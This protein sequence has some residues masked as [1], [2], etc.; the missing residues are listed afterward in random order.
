MAFISRGLTD[1]EIA[2]KTNLALLIIRDHIDNNLEKL[3]LNSHVQIS[4]YRSYN[5][6]VLHPALPTGK[7]KLEKEVR[8]EKAPIAV[9]KKTKKSR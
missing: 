1:T 9:P 5:E 8:T 3:A 4:I 6:D 2:A 7:L